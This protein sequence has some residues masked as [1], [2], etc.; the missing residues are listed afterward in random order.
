MCNDCGLEKLHVLLSEG[1]TPREEDSLGWVF[2]T[3]LSVMKFL[4]THQQGLPG[5]PV[6]LA[7]CSISWA[8]RG[9][10]AELAD[11]APPAAILLTSLSSCL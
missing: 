11:T 6:L 2:H 4:H 8:W 3:P 10:P 9:S 7:F 1:L 5:V